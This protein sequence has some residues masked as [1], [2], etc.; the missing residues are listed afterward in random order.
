[1][2]G[3]LDFFNQAKDELAKV[4]WPSRAQVSRLS[5]AVAAIS[6]AASLFLGF[7]DYG[8]GKFLKVVLPGA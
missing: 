4:T 3:V 8:L 7:L 5:L 1:M 2:R 6:V